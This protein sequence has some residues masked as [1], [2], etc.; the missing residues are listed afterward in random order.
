[1]T[2][3]VSHF[4]K[5]D[6]VCVFKSYIDGIADCYSL[7]TQGNG[8]VEECEDVMRSS[9]ETF[10]MNYSE[11]LDAVAAEILRYMN[12][13]G[14]KPLGGVDEYKLIYFM[15]MRLAAFLERDGSELAAKVI[16]YSAVLML[17]DRLKTFTD[18]RGRPELKERALMLIKDGK[19][20]ERLGKD[21]LYLVYKCSSNM[22]KL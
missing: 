8:G 11:I 16:R 3:Y 9:R 18:N 20:T 1:M 5:D 2:N 21:G 12:Y 6:I 10:G 19:L 14:V 7:Y 22:L 13:Y 17:D 15:G 4:H